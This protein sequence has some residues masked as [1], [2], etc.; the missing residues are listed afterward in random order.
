MQADFERR[1][2]RTRVAENLL[3]A[4]MVRAAFPSFGH[5]GR[6]NIFALVATVALSPRA[7]GA[8]PDPAT[9]FGRPVPV[10]SRLTP[11]RRGLGHPE[12]PAPR[13]VEPPAPQA[14][15]AR[16]AAT[17]R[18]YAPSF[19]SRLTRVFVFDTSDQGAKLQVFQRIT[20][21]ASDWQ[22]VCTGNCVTSVYVGAIY[23]VDGP[24]MPK[25]D[26]FAVQ[27]GG[28]P[29][30]LKAEMGSNAGRAGGYIVATV[31]GITMFTGMLVWVANSMCYF[32]GEEAQHRANMRALTTGGPIMLGGI[33]ILVGGSLLVSSNGTSLDFPY[34][35]ARES[36]PLL[37]IG[38]G[39]EL[40]LEGLKF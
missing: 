30:N 1:L 3:F 7:H 5:R 25:S 10:P 17:P 8:E 2:A 22:T 14:P 11:N 6:S 19:D 13:V 18:P 4:L 39:L 21:H 27:P 23:R 32:C 36:K 20:P 16:S 15:P 40:T 28:T 9:S 31:G 35:G 26:S 38:K 34:G 24:G 33:L 12:R 29:V 37:R